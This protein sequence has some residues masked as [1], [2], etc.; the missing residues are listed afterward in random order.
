MLVFTEPDELESF[1]AKLKL[2]QI[3]I[4]VYA[5]QLQLSISREMMSSQLCLEHTLVAPEHTSNIVVI[6]PSLD[7][8]HQ[9]LITHLD[10][11]QLWTEYNF[12]SPVLDKKTDNRTDKISC[13][14]NTCSEQRLY[15]EN[16]P[17]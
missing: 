13:G 1:E 14:R 6:T 8:T 16:T 3:I 7:R 10:R 11:N 17:W 15:R 4:Y 9:I 5:F 2:M 12:I